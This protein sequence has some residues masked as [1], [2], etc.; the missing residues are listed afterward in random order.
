MSS[1]SHRR[2]GS[3]GLK[4]SSVGLGTNNFG[5][6]LDEAASVKVVHA[7]L[8]AGITLIDTADVYGAGESERHLGSALLG[9]RDQA[10]VA[11]KFA[12]PM[13]EGPNDRGGSRAHV[14]S[15]LE[16]S[17]RRLQTDYVDLYQ[18]HFPDSATPLEE[19]LAALDDAV[20]AGKVRYLGSSNFSGW[21]IADADWMAR[22][23]GWNRFVSA[24]NGYSLLS[25]G[26]QREVIPACLRFGQGMIPYS[27]LAGGM[28]TGKYRRG[29]PGPEGARLSG[30]SQAARVLSDRNFE[31]VDA[32]AAYAAERG[33]SLLHVAIG[34]LAA[35]P[36]VASVIAGASSPEQILANVE[37]GSWVP[38][39]EDLVALDKVAP[40]R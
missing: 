34:G 37:A 21:Q 14:I 31:I 15:A 8:D 26:V 36:A 2:L 38:T 17:L 20:R 40:A 19:T 4:V 9:R 6:R 29:E 3:S 23:N 7:A 12:A 28:L 32:L 39:S 16:A 11:T 1:I 25:R 27:P 5:R 33:I 22:T 35:Q 24:Q 30:D 10:I 18:M 13:G